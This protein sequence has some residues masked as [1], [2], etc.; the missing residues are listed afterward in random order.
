M[1]LTP[2]TRPFIEAET[3]SSFILTNMHDGLLPT[4]YYRNV[5]DFG[6]GET[7]HIKTIGDVRIQE[8][9]EDTALEYSPIDTGEVTLKIT[10]YV[11][12]AWFVN[13]DLREDGAQVDQ[14]MAAR[15]AESTRALQ[16]R[17]ESRFLAVC[18]EAQTD[19]N[20]NTINKF[21]HRLASAETDNV[22]AL[23]HFIQMKLAFDKAEVPYGGRVAIIDPVC[24]ATLDGLVQ[25]Q[26]D[27]TPFAE[28]IMENGFDREHTFL[29]N[30][31]GWNIIT[32]NR[33]DKGTFS[34]GTT[35]VTDGVANVFMNVIDD[36]T[37][38]I[39]CAWRR[40]PKV[41]GDRNVQLRRDQFQVT[42]RY[43]FGPQR[44]DSLGILIT[45]AVKY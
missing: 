30:L 24:G 7:L 12:D 3:Y 38:P 9:A 21:P 44:L 27:V 4:T 33:L 37:K 25:I 18:N 1:H 36:N 6:K 2:N 8:A 17:F 39:M 40:M 32:S 15:S 28:K 19:G 11:G 29:M 5:S 16:E 22:L 45:S 41:E 26:S 13:D 14:L 23:K 10:D 35:S 34:D 31:Y 20:A 43:G 42:S